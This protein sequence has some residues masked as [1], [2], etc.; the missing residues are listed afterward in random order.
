MSDMREALD[1]DSFDEFVSG[2]YAARD[3]QVPPLD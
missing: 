1:N 2:F 3:Q